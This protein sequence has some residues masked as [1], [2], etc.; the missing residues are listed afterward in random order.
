[1]ADLARNS[2]HTARTRIRHAAD[3]GE[4]RAERGKFESMV[5]ASADR[6]LGHPGSTGHR[7]AARTGGRGAVGDGAADPVQCPS[8]RGR[9][10]RGADTHGK[11]RPAG[12]TPLSAGQ[13]GGSHAGR[14][15]LAIARRAGRTGRRPAPTPATCVGSEHV[16]GSRRPP[17]CSQ[18]GRPSYPGPVGG[19]A[20]GRLPTGRWTSTIG[21]G[22]PL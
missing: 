22:R 18:T 3:R 7:A 5:P 1:M 19:A 4:R 12:S 6:C 17:S 9:R 2:L 13:V 11:P 10:D 14:P 21:P 20:V 15:T 8:D 16:H